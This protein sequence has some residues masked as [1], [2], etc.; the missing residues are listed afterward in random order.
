MA[1][2]VYGFENER[3]V[4]DIVAASRQTLSTARSGARRTRRQPIL[5]SNT[6]ST[7]GGGGGGGSDSGCECGNCLK[8]VTIPE[9][10]VCCKSHLR[11][12]L[13]NPWTA[14]AQ[15][16]LFLEFI[17]DD[18]WLT[19]PFEGPDENEY[20]WKMEPDVAGRS[21]LTLVVETGTPDPPICVVY[22]R[23]SFDC[24]CDNEFT[25]AKPYGKWHGVKRSSLLCHACIKPEP[26]ELGEF[27]TSL[28]EIECGFGDCASD[29][30]PG[31]S[32]EF[33]N[34]VVLAA[35]GFDG[36][37]CRG[38]EAEEAAFR[39]SNR[40][41]PCENGVPDSFFIDADVNQTWT[42]DR[43]PPIG[44]DVWTGRQSYRLGALADAHC[45]VWSGTR[46]VGHI[47][48]VECEPALDLVSTAVVVLMRTGCDYWFEA[49]FDYPGSSAAPAGTLVYY[50]DVG[51]FAPTNV[52][53]DIIDW[54][55][56]PHSM[57]LATSAPSCISN[58]EG[59]EQ[60]DCSDEDFDDPTMGTVDVMAAATF[61]DLPQ[62]EP[63]I[64]TGVCEET[65]E[66]TP[67]APEDPDSGA[68][69]LLGVCFDYLTEE[70]CDDVGGDW[71]SEG[72]GDC[73]TP[74]PCCFGS[75][76]IEVAESLCTRWGGEVVED[77]CDTEPC[78]TGNDT[79]TTGACCDGVGGCAQTTS[80]EC[81]DTY[82]G[83]DVSCDECDNVA[84]CESGEITFCVA[85][86]AGCLGGGASVVYPI[87]PGCSPGN[88]C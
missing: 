87:P 67:E 60:C 63:P 68:C 77:A 27:D 85:S 10:L 24:Q 35:D 80:G 2:R 9:A 82:L 39:F 12:S 86:V 78:F 41:N 52:V 51:S 44:G 8:G 76:C 73:E 37:W 36:H 79:P 61:I 7:G 65:C 46:A 6:S 17:G 57:T 5:S 66:E 34:Q 30:E 21:Y 28:Q 11:W 13:R 55:N 88:S 23:E 53:Q 4:R 75:S 40:S 26:A 81:F 58:T 43:G 48:N 45:A 31:D 18:V 56:A 74:V 33:A 42:C 38:F 69:C 47:G 50:S 64:D 70:L 3:D 72:C 59:S 22:G 29:I 1:K 16:E 25:I 49:S 84:C 14:C 71:D 15:S 19:D 62:D 54:F 20:R 83:D 32:I